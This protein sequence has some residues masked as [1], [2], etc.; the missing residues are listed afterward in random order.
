MLSVQKAKYI[1]TLM[2]I[3]VIALV[4]FDISAIQFSEAQTSSQMSG[5]VLTGFFTSHF[6]GSGNC[7]LCHSALTDTA[8]NDVSIDA[9]WRSTMMGNA[10]RDPLWQAKVS[11]EVSR[12]PALKTII[13]D[14]C[15]TC[16]TPMARTQAISD[17]NPANLLD[18]GFLD[19]AHALN[20]PAMDGVS[21]TLCHQIQD[22]DLGEPESFSGQYTIDTTNIA[23]DRL[24]FGPF[25]N[26]VQNMMRGNV[27]FT[28]VQ[29]LHITESALC[30]TCHTLYTPYVDAA[31]NVLG[32]FP[33]QTPYLEWENSVYS[34][35][36][37]EG[38]TCQQ[39]HMPEANGA[40]IISNRPIGRPTAP[41]SP[42]GLHHFV[43]GNAFMLNVLESQIQ[44]LGLT[45]SASHLDTTLNRTV[46]Q[47]QTKTALL[48][49]IDTQIRDNALTVT[50][51][52]ENKVGHKF[53]SGFPSR[54][55]WVHLIVTDADGKTV[56]ESGKPKADGSIAG[57]DADE[58]GSAYEL[59]HDVISS[60]DQ[61]QIY[62]PIMQNSEGKVTYTLLR[63][64]S[65]AKDNRLLPLG[66]DK[67]SAS[68]DVAARG[69]AMHDVSFVGGGD[70]VTY[71]ISASGYSGPFVVAAE[72]LYQTIAH[73]FMLDL[74]QD[75][76]DPL[77]DRFS[78]YYDSTDKTPILIHKVEYV[79]D[80]RSSFE[81]WDINADGSVDI[82]DIMIVASVFGV[83]GVGLAA[84]VNGDDTVNILD[85]VIVGSHLKNG[86]N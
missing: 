59:H 8:G 83:S 1:L 74:Q 37:T 34:N 11:S 61:V 45:A 35:S 21:C 47:L 57:N 38:K 82:S 80:A 50:L 69:K 4:S 65:Y 20:E 32:K 5:D 85:L 27:G 46:K 7:A 31:G 2:C 30:A 14:K 29:G 53:P 81:P 36:G 10:A 18:E 33:E 62:E 43:G 72:L 9:D 13:E 49:I 78:H 12:N 25:P 24:I 3:L 41:R 73:R 68:E 58:N 15:A 42:F 26:P 56:F 22:I 55:A 63:G 79:T 44:E 75:S 84:D 17:G 71:Q 39:C 16:H 48:S 64:A 28:P 51:H 40:V 6:S 52:V 23:P 86:I 54:R 76:T 60:P 66:F 67:E 70:S 77:V 19:P